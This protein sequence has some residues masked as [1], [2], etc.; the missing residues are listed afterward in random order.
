MSSRS[1]DKE[2]VQ[3]SF[4]SE[5]IWSLST[6][7]LL[8]PESRWANEGKI[9]M[10]KYCGN[11]LAAAS[12]GTGLALRE[13]TGRGLLDG[14]K[15]IGLPKGITLESNPP[16]IGIVGGIMTGT[17]VRGTPGR[18]ARVCRPLES[19]VMSIGVKPGW[20]S[21]G[22]VSREGFRVDGAGVVLIVTIGWD[23]ILLIL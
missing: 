23:S 10:E 22:W 14:V 13:R 2:L 4:D 15:T 8:A 19:V 18:G 20:F 3:R 1:R 5:G 6:E 16:K 21:E 9:G 17:G 7:S 12:I 11:W